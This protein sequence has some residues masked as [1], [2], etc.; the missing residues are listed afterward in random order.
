MT[1]ENGSHEPVVSCRVVRAVVQTVRRSHHESTKV[2]ER[3]LRGR[4]EML[5]SGALR[6]SV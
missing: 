3:R 1:C 2:D 5:P 6:V 4:I